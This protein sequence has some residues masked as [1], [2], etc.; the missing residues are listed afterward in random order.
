MSSPDAAGYQKW[1]AEE[2]CEI[3]GRRGHSTKENGMGGDF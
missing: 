1:F 2:G 3:W